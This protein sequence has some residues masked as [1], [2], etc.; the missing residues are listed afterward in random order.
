MY[1]SVCVDRLLIKDTPAYALSAFKFSQSNSS[2][3]ISSPFLFLSPHYCFLYLLMVPLSFEM[4]F[5]EFLCSL[6]SAQR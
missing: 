1:I 6:C 4:S 3:F 2:F 5:E